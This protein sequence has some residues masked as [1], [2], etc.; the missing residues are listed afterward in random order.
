MLTCGVVLLNENARPHTGAR[1]RTLLEHLDWEWFDYPS[2]SRDLAPSD[3]HLFTRTCLKNWLRSQ[4]FN[5]NNG[6]CQNVAE[7]ISG[8]LLRH[9]HTETYSP[10]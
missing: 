7:L 10:I 8:R 9:R 5:N 3:Y 4:R 1:T 6:R 2:H